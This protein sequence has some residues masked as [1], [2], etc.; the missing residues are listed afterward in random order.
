M[1]KMKKWLFSAAALLVLAGQHHATAQA[2][3]TAPV[4]TSEQYVEYG[5][6]SGR[7][8]IIADVGFMILSPRFKDNPAYF[9]A[10][11]ISDDGFTPTVT[12]QKDFDFDC[13]FVPQLYLG[14]IG[15]SGLGIRVGWWGFALSATETTSV[16]GSGT[17][18]FVAANPLQLQEVTGQTLGAL[19]QPKSLIT[20]AKLR[21]NVWDFEAVQSFGSGSWS[22]LG[23][24][25][26][27]YAHISQDYNAENFLEGGEAN[28]AIFSGHNLNGAGPTLSLEARREIGGSNLYLYSKTRG[29]VLFGST[30]QFGS[31]ALFN[32]GFG[33]GPGHLLDADHASDA[34]IPVGELELGGGFQRETGLGVLFL[35]AGLVGQAWGSV[36]NSSQSAGSPSFA[37]D[38]ENS[39]INRESTLGLIGFSLRGGVSY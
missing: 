14:Y 36:G 7:G 3:T 31:I 8:G 26:I 37:I 9:G 39:S 13:Q 1:M 29:S 34:V 27:R 18:L 22:G 6:D 20:V 2:P 21:M 10:I 12:T 19:N 35:Q 24:L 30:K 25:G 5:N 11:G 4:I 32:G 15:G 17:Q 28:V 38:N 16:D 33:P 23:S